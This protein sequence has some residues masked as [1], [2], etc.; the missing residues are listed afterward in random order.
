MARRPRSI[1]SLDRRSE[2]ILRAVIDEY[3]ATAT[4]VGSQALVN[5]Y[6]LGVSS[7]TVRNILVQLETGGFVRQPHTSAGRVPTD[8]GYRFY[9]DLLLEGRRPTRSDAM[10]GRRLRRAS[11]PHQRSLSTPAARRRGQRP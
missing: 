7:A 2:S 5:R 3:V 10:V 9:V 8:R 6:G 4:P 1:G 11:E